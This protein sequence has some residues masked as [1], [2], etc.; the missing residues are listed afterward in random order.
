VKLNTDGQNGSATLLAATAIVVLGTALV[1]AQLNATKTDTLA[2]SSA[3]SMATGAQQAAALAAADGAAFVS[4]LSSNGLCSGSTGCSGGVYGS[5]ALSGGAG[6]QSSSWWTTSNAHSYAYTG[7]NT[8][9]LYA[10]EYLSCDSTGLTTYRITGRAVAN[11]SFNVVGGKTFLYYR[12]VTKNWGVLTGT[13]TGVFFNNISSSG[14]SQNYPT[15]LFTSPT[16]SATVT[17]NSSSTGS[18]LN[19][20]S[21]RT[22][23]ITMLNIRVVVASPLSSDCASYVFTFRVSK[24]GGAVTTYSAAANDFSYQYDSTY[25]VNS[26]TKVAFTP[27]D[28]NTI[29]GFPLSPTLAVSSGDSVQVIV[30][31]ENGPAPYYG[32]STAGV[33]IGVVSSSDVTPTIKLIGTTTGGGNCPS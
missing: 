30:Y 20:S 29:Y 3:Q 14:P 22:G 6:N 7:L 9:P 10:I 21:G 11:S 1:V 19:F 15:P 13:T 4:A 26:C 17:L 8:T 23:Y 16:S 24:N 32:I 2:T 12:T 33:G 5:S 31:G 28:S 18:T 25:L 27:W